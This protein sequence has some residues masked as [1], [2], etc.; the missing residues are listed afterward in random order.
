MKIYS[1]QNV[2]E[3]AKDR[4]RWLFDEFPNVVVDISGGKDSTVVFHLAIEIAREK[5]RLPLRVM[6]LDQEAEWQA[7]VDTVRQI[8][9]REDVEP[10]WYQIPFKLFNA[11]SA[12][13]HWL[14]CW[15]P[16]EE[17]RWMRPKE[18]YAIT[19]NVYGTDRFGELFAAILKHDFAGQKACHIAGVRAEE[20]P[21]R[22]L[23]L[24]TH[25]AYKWATWGKPEKSGRGSQ[26]YTMYPIYDWSYTDVWKAIHEH[27]WPYNPIYDAQYAYGISVLNMR[28]S[29]VHHETAVQALF[30][31]QEVEPETYQKLTQRISGIDT[32][33]KLGVA[34]YF[35][36]SLP[37][38]FS[39]WR[40]YRDF[41]LE[42]LILDPEWR[43]KLAA[44]FA[45]DEATYG[46][47]MGDKLCRVH[48]A[49]ILTNDHEMVKLNNFRA[50]H[51]AFE[52]RKKVKQKKRR[53][54][55]QTEK[56]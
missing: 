39:S 38:M 10:L 43:R 8:M 34:D 1:K 22:M 28:V 19:E 3:A 23:G 4:I 55:A 15:N 42:K 7:T 12:S 54:A 25:P 50:S 11:T 53:A 40:E 44:R 17:H 45:D 14:M 26:H 31:M 27:G 16:E 2:L 46:D 33:G 30:Y 51:G 56:A 47:E 5:G 35:P 49:S 32:A 36:K 18:P 9:T 48:I 6:F 29:N 20:S 41:L 13:E 21:A 37:F 52:A 24:T